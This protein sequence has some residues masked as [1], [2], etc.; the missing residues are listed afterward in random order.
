MIEMAPGP[1]VKIHG[2]GEKNSEGE[3][4]PL[5]SG[6]D[7]EQCRR[8][9]TV[10]KLFSKDDKDKKSELYR[11]DSEAIVRLGALPY[12]SPQNFSNSK[13]IRKQVYT[14]LSNKLG[15]RTQFLC[16]K[17]ILCKKTNYCG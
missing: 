9:L 17:T 13:D 3:F 6:I 11:M 12:G 14:K 15:E 8:A 7:Q 4:A 2:Y 16:K 10:L 1:K 5:V